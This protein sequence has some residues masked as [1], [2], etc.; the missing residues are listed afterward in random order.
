MSFTYSA[1]RR[2]CYAGYIVQGIVNNLSPVLFIVFQEDFG[3]SYR[4]LGGLI[5][6]NF[7]TQLV[8]DVLGARFIDQIGY[9][10]PIIAAHAC[11]ALGLVLLP[12]L[13]HVLPSPLLGLA[14]ATVF[15]AMGGGLLEVLVSPMVNSLPAP[16][17]RKAAMMSLLH[18]FYCWGQL[19][20]VLV[21]ALLLKAAGGRWEFLPVFW[22]L[23]PFGNL[24]VFLK[25]PLAA[26]IPAE[27]RTG[28]W[29]LIGTPA[30]AA[31]LLM[32]LCAG[33]AELTISQ[34]ASLFAERALGLPKLWGDLAGPCMFALLM[35]AGR[36]FFG[37]YGAK[38]RL[39]RFILFSS[40]LCVACYLA[41]SLAASP[42]INLI[43]CAAA[44]FAVSI[45]WPGMLS[46]AS[47]RFPLGGTAMFA[48]MAMMGDAGCAAGPW[49]AGLIAE[50]SAGGLKTGILFGTVFPAAMIVTMLMLLRKKT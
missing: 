5:L 24:F 49:S 4:Q 42:V 37:I 36:V 40:L 23:I 16:E 25:V 18:S 17:H 45:M 43:G 29:K 11:A 9:R 3:L 7:I 47:K 1:T 8:V 32:M 15:S 2:A 30:F 38:I 10:I 39:E 35:G 34:W 22:A 13:P 44:G 19:M 6:L 27:H 20:V 50:L 46:F 33:A 26:T 12:I 21:T 48:I 28:L 41:A 14:V 31:I